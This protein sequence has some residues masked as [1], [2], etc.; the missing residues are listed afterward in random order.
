MIICQPPIRPKNKHLQSILASSKVRLLRLR[1]GNP[2]NEN[3][4]EQTLQNPHATL[5][6]Y[7]TQNPNP[8]RYCRHFVTWLGR[9]L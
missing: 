2:V 7:Y 1:K 4:V 9:Q 8:I 6:G 3:Q 5:L